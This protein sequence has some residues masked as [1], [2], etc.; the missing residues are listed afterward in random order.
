MFLLA[1]ISL[2]FWLILFVSALISY[3]PPGFKLEGWD[4]FIWTIL[5]FYPA[6][7]GVASFIALLAMGFNRP[8]FGYWLMGGVMIAVIVT[9]T[10][11]L[12]IGSIFGASA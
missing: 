2:C 7:L 4:L 6:I 11:Y 10:A 5:K 8:R 1:G 3:R 12:V 9:C